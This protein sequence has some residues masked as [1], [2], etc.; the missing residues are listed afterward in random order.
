[1]DTN[2]LAA[3]LREAE[4]HHGDYE[5]T[6]PPHRWSDWYAGYIVARQDGR[7]PEDA[8]AAATAHVEAVL[9]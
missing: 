9:R 6:A 5:P 8:V 7:R 3:L 1:M 2:D 4:A